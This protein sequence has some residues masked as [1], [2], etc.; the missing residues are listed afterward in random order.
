MLA[1][2]FP[3]YCKVRVI[4]RDTAF[5]LR[6]IIRTALVL[7]ERLLAQHNKAMSKT[8]GNKELAVILIA[9]LYS[10]MLAVG[11]GAMSNIYSD[12]EHPALYTAYQLALAIR[13][14]LVMQASQHT[15]DRPGLVILHKGN[16]AYLLPELAVRKGFEKIAAGITKHAR[17]DDDQA[18]D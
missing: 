7:K 2:Q 11:W 14:T 13:L 15:V 3:I 10:N 17:L 1:G 9:Q 5:T 4:P 18:R 6:C 8:S 12:I 16:I